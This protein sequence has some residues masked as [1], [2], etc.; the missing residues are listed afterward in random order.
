MR[1]VAK[2]VGFSLV[3]L[4]VVMVIIGL[5]LALLLPAV[6]RAR[7]IARSAQCRNNL[8]NLGIAYQN[9]IASRTERSTPGRTLPYA[10][11]WVGA[12]LPFT[13]NSAVSFRCPEATTDYFNASGSSFWTTPGPSA[14]MSLA[15]IGQVVNGG[16]AGI[17][18][19]KA[20]AGFGVGLGPAGPPGALQPGS[21]PP[22]PTSLAKGGAKLERPGL[23]GKIQLRA[24]RRRGRQCHPAG[25]QRRG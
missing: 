5:L 24:S 14:P 11:G 20:G 10:F 21:G 8:H 23:S 13:D 17:Q 6:H 19:M 22:P 12:L 9:L 3:E 1:A 2:R 25:I 16:I 15:A 4:L 7:A 18:F